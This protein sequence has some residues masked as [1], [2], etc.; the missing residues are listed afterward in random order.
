M[1]SWWG[2]RAHTERVG[3]QSPEEWAEWEVKGPRKAHK[4]ISE[5]TALI[6]ENTE[7]NPTGSGRRAT[8]EGRGPGGSEPSTRTPL[9]LTHL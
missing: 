1:R 5:R 3:H 6:F 4:R 9:T 2:P 8:D 7:I